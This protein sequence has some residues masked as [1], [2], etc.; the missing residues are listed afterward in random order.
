MN[1]AKLD[2]ENLN[3]LIQDVTLTLDKYFSNFDTEV[4]DFLK[5]LLPFFV[6]FYFKILKHNA[7]DK[8]WIHKDEVIV[9]NNLFQILKNILEIHINHTQINKVSEIKKYFLENSY[10]TSQN[11]LQ[12]IIDLVE[13]ARFSKKE[14]EK[15]K[16]AN[17][18][19]NK[20]FYILIDQSEI[21]NNYHTSQLEFI[22]KNNYSE[23][24]ILVF[25]RPILVAHF[26]KINQAGSHSSLNFYQRESD[27]PAIQ[28][29]KL[30][31]KLNSLGFDVLV[32]DG[33]DMIAIE[34]AINY[35][36]NL[37]KPTVILLNIN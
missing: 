22:I 6:V 35:A 4:L 18:I 15:E 13:F 27:K 26:S 2:T 31:A 32:T 20:T 7:K 9:M 5:K 12:E 8:D 23:I 14:N 29:H 24:L 3:I 36:K 10:L 16:K 1:N 21:I 37:Q 17:Q 25:V 11:S 30:N 34:R 19:S 33:S 28:D